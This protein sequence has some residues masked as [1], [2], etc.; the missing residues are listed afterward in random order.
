MRTPPDKPRQNPAQ[1]FPAEPNVS[2]TA[3]NDTL[4]S[5][6]PTRRLPW[7]LRMEEIIWSV[8]DEATD[9]IPLVKRWLQIAHR[10]I[11]G[12][13]DHDGFDNASALT[14]TTL[15]SLVPLLTLLIAGLSI[16]GDKADV[17]REQVKGYSLFQSLDITIDTTSGALPPDE[18]EAPAVATTAS[19]VTRTQDAPRP[20]APAGPL[21]APIEISGTDLVDLIFNFVR[22]AEIQKHGVLGSI[23]LLWTVLMLLSRVEAALNRAWSIKRQ[24]DWYRKVGDYF[25][26]LAVG[27][28]ILLALTTTTGSRIIEELPLDFIPGFLYASNFVIGHIAYLIIWPAFIIIYRFVPNTRV[29]WR[30][31]IAGS[32][33]AGTLYQLLQILFINSSFLIIERYK[34][35]YGSFALLFVFCLWIYIS[36]TIALWGA[37]VCSAHQNLRNLRRQRR[38][39]RGLPYEIETLALRLTS[40]LAAP[41]VEAA[42]AKP[43]DAGDLAD[44]LRCPPDPLHEMIELFRNSGLLIQSSDDG[45]FLLARSPEH[46]S[47]LDILRLIR[48]GRLRHPAPAGGQSDAPG[49]LFNIDHAVLEPLQRRTAADLAVLPL[50]SIRAFRI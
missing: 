45:T 30:S 40:L 46:V 15:L 32:L 29:L 23:G 43:M 24:R 34:A 21:K 8:S 33:V 20:P 27:V 48:Q 4:D 5:E 12:F 42:G 22:E 13:H 14:F 36:W 6:A 3:A 28:F 10:S 49:E 38:V 7:Y 31:A 37:E 9:R 11:N 17:I 47:V 16:F 35:I 19:T 26:I 50:D 2:V 44:A 39:W 41:M 25:K 1:P 18:V